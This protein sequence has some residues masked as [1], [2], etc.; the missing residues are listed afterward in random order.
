[1]QLAANQAPSEKRPE[2]DADQKSLAETKIKELF[3]DE[4][5]KSDATARIGLAVKLHQLGLDTKDDVAARFML[6]REAR[7][8]AARAG[9]V[10]LALRAVDAIAKEYEI[11][12]VAMKKLALS[13]AES[14]VRTPEGNK[15]LAESALAVA[16]EA[17]ANDDYDTAHGLLAMADS[18]ARKTKGREL[19]SLVDARKTRVREIEK[20]Y[21]DVKAVA[22]QLQERP[23]DPEANLQMGKFLCFVKGDWGRGLP[24]LARSGDAK[25]KA[26]A[27][28][29]LAKPT[30]ATAQ[31]ELAN[32]WWDLGETTDPPAK[33]MIEQQARQW[34]KRAIPG[35]T[36]LNK[37]VAEKRLGPAIVNSPSTPSTKPTEKSAEIRSFKG[38]TDH[39]YCAAFV[40]DGKRMV[41]CGRDTT[42]RLWELETGKE[43]RRYEG[44]KDAVWSVAVSPDG[45]RIFSGSHDGTA[46]VWDLET[47]QQLASFEQH[48]ESVRCVAFSPD[49]RRAL[50]GG[51]SNTIIYWDMKSVRPLMKLDHPSQVVK[52][53]FTR[54]GRRALSAGGD[55]TIRIWD[56]TNGQTVGKLEG[57]KGAVL[58]LALSADGR[59]AISCGQEKNIRVWELATGRQT[60]VLESPS[61]EVWGVGFLPDGQRAVSAGATSVRVWDIAARREIAR[62]EG[63]TEG[64]TYMAVSSDGTHALTTSHDLTVRL[65]KLPT[66]KAVAEKRASK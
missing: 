34:Y 15:Q 51:W 48:S 64:I 38:H 47:G 4:Y 63:H 26:L 44:H 50:S 56:L 61:A 57:H 24:Y 36:G 35:L 54:D 58:N 30:E 41:S 23:D 43:L 1:V 13:T 2:P 39:V 19:L 53:V 62:L 10:T 17:V 11:D 31:F 55:G 22:Q 20:A 32:A 21:A 52:L 60:S 65:W 8:L 18:A 6:F 33:A 9:D 25:L 3:K 12:S 16:D 7:D 28:K 5:A 59:R 37:A 14:A 49:S 45:S 29:E 42:I 40:P 27:A 66:G 46:R